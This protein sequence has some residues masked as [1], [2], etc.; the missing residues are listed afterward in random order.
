MMKLMHPTSGP[1]AG[2]WEEGTERLKD[3]SAGM[4]AQETYTLKAFVM[5][6]QT[7]TFS[8]LLLPTSR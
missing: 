5:A 7:E 3:D 6:Q 8:L 2:G 4:K 1:A